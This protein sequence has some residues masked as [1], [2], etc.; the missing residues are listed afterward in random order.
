MHRDHTGAPPTE[1]PLVYFICPRNACRSQMA[2]GF[3]RALAGDRC[4]I[5]SG[6]LRPTRLDPRAVMVMLEAGVDIAAQRAKPVDP[7]CLR[8]AAA[9]ISLCGDP[10]DLCPVVPPPTRHLHWEVPDPACAEGTDAEALEAFRRV[11]NAI[12]RRVSALLEEA[13]TP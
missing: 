2:E 5:R 10:Q 11:R 4:E 1:R 9:A 8:R 7:A 12:Y 3:A 6:G 13:P